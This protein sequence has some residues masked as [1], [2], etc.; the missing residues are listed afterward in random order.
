MVVVEI[1]WSRVPIMIIKIRLF[2][3]QSRRY[4]S[5]PATSTT[6]ERAMSRMG[7]CTWGWKIYQDDVFIW[8]LECPI[9]LKLSKS[10]VKC[11]KSYVFHTIYPTTI[12]FPSS[13]YI[14]LLSDYADFSDGFTVCG[15]RELLKHYRLH[16]K[17]YDDVRRRIRTLFLWAI[18]ILNRRKGRGW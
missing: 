8:C 9:I 18:S 15:F 6:A 12:C 2:T 1:S 5:V 7:F 17:N 11:S 10:A 4:L 14:S 13:V 16:W 3:L